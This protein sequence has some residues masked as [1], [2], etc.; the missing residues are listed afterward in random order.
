MVEAAG[1]ESSVEKNNF[2][3]WC[4]VRHKTVVNKA[5]RACLKFHSS[6][7]RHAPKRMTLP[8]VCP[9]L[10]FLGMGGGG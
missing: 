1:I 8:I 3:R 4:V 2:S 9:V 5:V 10:P 6:E 7:K